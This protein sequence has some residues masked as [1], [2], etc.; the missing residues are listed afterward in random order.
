[1]KI[2]GKPVTKCVEV[3]VLP[4]VDGD[5]V[6]KAEA[7]AIN[8]EFNAMVPMPTPPSVRT[9]EGR[10]DDT[11]DTNYLDALERREALRWDYMCLKSLAPS[12]IEWDEIDLSKP[13]TW[14]GWEK[15]LLE[16]GLSEVEVNRISGCVM[17]ANAL[18]ERKL[19]D[20]RESFL[21]GQDQ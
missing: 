8:E 12:E 13:S 10:R 21:H 4:R 3:L 20:A 2:G 11:E 14:L 1:M 9:K 15:E 17:A 6:I 7:V 18:D 5:L 16:A 19:K